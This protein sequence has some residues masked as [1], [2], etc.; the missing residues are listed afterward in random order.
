[1][2][3]AVPVFLLLLTTTAYAEDD[4]Y[5]D[6]VEGAAAS[7]A[8]ILYAPELIGSV[9]YVEQPP[10]AVNPDAN[11]KGLRLIAGVRYSLSN[12]YTGVATK[13]RA[14]ADCKRHRA[15][16]QVRGE[17][18][19]RAIAARLKVLDDALV[20]AEK[21]LK[22]DE[23]DFAARRTTAQEAT[24]T[25][26]RVEEIRSLAAEDHA[27][28][29][30][31]P[32][33]SEQPLGGALKNYRQADADVEDNEAKLRRAA[34]IDVSFRFGID[35]YAERDNP[36][37]YFAVISVGLNLG[38]LFQGDANK[39]SAAGR[40]KL[41]QSGQGP[42]VEATVDQLRTT[43]EIESK[44]AKE[45]QALV[46]ELERQ[47]DA[48][49]KIGGDESKRY[50]QTVWFEWVKAKAQHEYLATHVATIREVLGG[51]E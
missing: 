2:R 14:H 1:M 47:L 17:T 42:G 43:L 45:T 28:L 34:G 25:R 33:P 32:A 36:Q 49:G 11:Q 30:A 22:T 3:A 41:V 26:V 6:Y 50:K 8:A 51:T 35:Q 7:Q 44:R 16:E 13:D 9:G 18:Q 31:L 27:A 38:V 23:A 46:Q 4:G 29:S 37:P 40:H 20:E 21:I 24:T 19:S 48:L 15:F 12:I 39:R 5:C 10:A